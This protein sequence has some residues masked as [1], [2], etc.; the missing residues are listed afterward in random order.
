MQDYIEK[1]YLPWRG[2]G[3]KKASEEKTYLRSKMTKLEDKITTELALQMRQVGNLRLLC[4]ENEKRDRDEIERRIQTE[5][6][7]KVGTLGRY[8]T[9]ADKINEVRSKEQEKYGPM[10][11]RI[12]AHYA[13][14]RY[15]LEHENIIKADQVYG[16]INKRIEELQAR[17]DQSFFEHEEG[18][19]SKAVSMTENAKDD[20]DAP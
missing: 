12:E 9:G 7:S 19:H 1:L 4:D 18:T 13:L 5:V 10:S 6:K 17:L 8:I 15:T 3:D 2:L 20:D 14:I 16:E 11:K